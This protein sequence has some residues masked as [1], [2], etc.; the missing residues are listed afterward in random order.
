MNS[1]T[2]NVLLGDMFTG[3]APVFDLASM[4]SGFRTTPDVAVRCRSRLWPMPFSTAPALVNTS[5]RQ[6]MVGTR[7]HRGERPELAFGVPV[8]AF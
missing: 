2:L 3:A 5:R 7:P 1:G 4:A 6:T 8:V